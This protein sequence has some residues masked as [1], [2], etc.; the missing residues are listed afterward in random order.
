MGDAKKRLARRRGF[1]DGWTPEEVAAAEADALTARA[2]AA[3]ARSSSNSELARLEQL[4]ALS[5]RKII[6]APFDGVVG[7]RWKE[8]HAQI[9][10]GDRLLRFLP[11]APPIVRFAV[12]PADTL[13][14][15]EGGGIR[16]EV[17]GQRH[18]GAIVR[19]STAVDLASGLIFVEGDLD[20]AAA[21][22]RGLLDGMTARVTLS[23]TA[24]AFA[25]ID[26]AP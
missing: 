1:P 24:A 10:P 21:G 8:Q 14:L 26:P 23:S 7:L 6:A 13:R 9:E 11:L 18:Q 3:A 4:R 5:R 17:E 2:E 20:C 22:C 12:P 25:A 19:W 15:V 16:V